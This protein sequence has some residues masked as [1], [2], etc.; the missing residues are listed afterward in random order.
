MAKVDKIVLRCQQNAEDQTCGRGWCKSARNKNK[1]VCAM[2]PTRK[3]FAV[4]VD[5]KQTAQVS[6][7]KV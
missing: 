1:Y 5:E 2:M 3:E 6:E 4:V 7:R